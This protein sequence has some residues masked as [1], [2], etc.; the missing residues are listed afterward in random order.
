[1]K[2]V[3]CTLFKSYLIFFLGLSNIDCWNNKVSVH[4][5]KLALVTNAVTHLVQAKFTMTRTEHVNGH[6][7]VA[8]GENEVHCYFISMYDTRLEVNEET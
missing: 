5:R 8:F 3:D 4:P 7:K 2:I 6:I 1:M